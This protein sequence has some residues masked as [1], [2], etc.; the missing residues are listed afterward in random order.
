MQT[1][2]PDEPTEELCH[3]FTVEICKGNKAAEEFCR[4]WYGYC[5]AID[6]L[7]DTKEDGRPTMSNEA[8]LAIFA[9]AALLYNSPFYVLHR[10][11][12]FPLVLHVTNAYADSVVWE[13]S[14]NAHRR[15]IADVFRCCGDDML[16]IVAMICGSW[17][18]GRAV[19][20]KLRESDFLLQHDAQ[21][22]PI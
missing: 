21:G 14:P 22:R 7:I 8:I 2:K 10:N 13:K 1:G 18:N 4:L 5:H 6:D 19:S 11:M 3:A 17:E 9:N 12:L 15:N 16:I 20:G